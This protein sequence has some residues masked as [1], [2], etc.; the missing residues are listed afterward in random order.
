MGW[1]SPAAEP[2]QRW[3]QLMILTHLKQVHELAGDA[4]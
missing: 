2:V 3:G 1:T 4:A